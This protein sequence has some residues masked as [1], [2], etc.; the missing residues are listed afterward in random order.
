MNPV[1]V[2]DSVD[3]MNTSRRRAVALSA[4]ALALVTLTATA[5]ALAAA[6]AS[7]SARRPAAPPTGWRLS[8]TI[9]IRHRSAVLV[10]VDA[11]SADD[12]WAAGTTFSEYGTLL[13]PLL[14]HWNGRSWRQVALP[15]KAVS[16]F[17]NQDIFAN[18][19]ALS[20]TKVWAITFQGRF[21]RLACGRWSVGALPG[22]AGGRVVVDA[23]KALGPANVWAF[24]SRSLGPV[25]ALKFA[26]YA[27]RFD[28]RR[29]IRIPVPG[30][31]ILG[32]V[33]AIS[34][35]DIWAVAGGEQPITG[36]SEITRVLRWNGAAWRPVPVQPTLSRR[37]SV[38]AMLA[39]NDDDVWIGGSVP[40]SAAG[41]SEMAQHWDGKAWVQASPATPPTS[42]SYYL[43]SFAPST[44]GGFWAIGGNLIG[45]QR[46][47]RNS[48]GI[49]S[50]PVRSPWELYQLAAVP[51]TNSTWGVGW[52]AD[53]TKGLIV[54]HGPLPR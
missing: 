26:P 25:S 23:V 24:G 43:S 50:A 10:G 38:T 2:A 27:A 20:A 30:R 48:H 14:E 9:S 4:G 42:Q 54:I 21:F 13:R 12:A 32:P 6:G 37:A 35:R 1:R 46:L 3:G 16:H 51:D 52:S 22:T 11:V 18:V 17:G 49:W 19:A 45:P 5:Q 34:A 15:A 29:W 53:L 40:N 39:A 8:T 31:G 36:M 47:W 41:T 28:G 33:S 44:G 7:G